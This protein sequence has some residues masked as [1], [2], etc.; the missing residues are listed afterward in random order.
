MRESLTQ[1]VDNERFAGVYST[2]AT[3][4]DENTASVLYLH[5][6]VRLVKHTLEVMRLK[7]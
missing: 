2:G 7:R 4:D 6:R 5:L 3:T 1:T